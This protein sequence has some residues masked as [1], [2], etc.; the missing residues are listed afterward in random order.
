L[1]PALHE[2]YTDWDFQCFQS[3]V[4]AQIDSRGDI[5]KTGS[6]ID[7]SLVEVS[8]QRGLVSPLAFK[9]RS[10]EEKNTNVCIL[11]VDFAFTDSAS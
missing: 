11:R 4:D 2:L 7:A 5:T 1:T 10:F 6:I 9:L 8:R 3:W